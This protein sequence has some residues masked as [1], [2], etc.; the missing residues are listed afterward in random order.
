MSYKTHKI[1]DSFTRLLK[2][3]AQ[4]PDGYF[5]G[6]TVL[7]QVR[8]DDYTLLATVTTEWF[9]PLTTRFLKLRVADTTEW[10][11]GVKL[12]DVQFTRASDSEVMSTTTA[13]FL[14]EKDVSR[15]EP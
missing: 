5:V 15:A 12:M 13:T 2:M 14:V 3:P 6:W 11:D 9:D 1:G 7:C 10:T 8:N 4:Y